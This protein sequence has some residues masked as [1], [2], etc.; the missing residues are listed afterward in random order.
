MKPCPSCRV[1]IANN[2]RRCP[3]CGFAQPSAAPS[4]KSTERL[5]ALGY[6]KRREKTFYQFWWKLSIELARGPAAIALDQHRLGQLDRNV[7]C[8]HNHITRDIKP[9]GSGCSACDE[10]H[11]R[12]NNSCGHLAAIS[13]PEIR[14]RFDVEY[15]INVIAL[16]DYKFRYPKARGDRL[17]LYK[18]SVHG[19][20]SIVCRF[21]AT[22]LHTRAK[23]GHDYTRHSA[24]WGHVRGCA[25]ESLTQLREAV[26]P[27][28]MP[29]VMTVHV[30]KTGWSTVY[31]HE[32]G[33]CEP[34]GVSPD[35]EWRC[36]NPQQTK[37]QIAPNQN[38][39]RDV[40]YDIGRTSGVISEVVIADLARRT[41]G[42]CL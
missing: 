30:L 9:V 17:W 34:E 6:D 36:D 39:E 15:L 13:D 11:F 18:G 10:Y 32:I 16:A 22:I 40:V 38:P 24:V 4:L 25:L 2:L 3:Q 28:P 23:V 19:G 7:D 1:S 41:A 12:N 35:N 21:C 20:G 42:G 5:R 31:G 29:P 37:F 33:L 27:Q 26:P 14:W 8:L